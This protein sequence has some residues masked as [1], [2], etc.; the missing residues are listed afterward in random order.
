[1]S[2]Y[3]TTRSTSAV[4]GRFYLGGG[5]LLCSLLG[6]EEFC[7]IRFTLLYFWLGILFSSITLHILDKEW[8]G[9]YGGGHRIWSSR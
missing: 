6:V 5:F 7:R 3:H 9:Q 4:L 8:L 1:M 2:C